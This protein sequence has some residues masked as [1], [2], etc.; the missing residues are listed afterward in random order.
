M[1][2]FSKIV[3]FPG[4]LGVRFSEDLD[5]AIVQGSYVES[6]ALPP[7]VEKLLRDRLSRVLQLG[8]RKRVQRR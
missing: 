6:N 5:A 8:L 2:G 7:I 3:Y 1:S 4:E